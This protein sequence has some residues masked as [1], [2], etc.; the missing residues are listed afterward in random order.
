ML[1]GKLEQKDHELLIQ[2][3]QIVE[4][5]ILIQQKEALLRRDFKRKKRQMDMFIGSSSDSEDLGV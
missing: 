3:R 1:K 2:S 5:N 4:K